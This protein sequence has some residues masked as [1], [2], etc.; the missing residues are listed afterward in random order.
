MKGYMKPL[1]DDINIGSDDPD[2]LQQFYES[3]L[4]ATASLLESPD[5]GLCCHQG[6]IRGRN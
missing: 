4:D 3:A 5:E 2:L 1:L 6:G